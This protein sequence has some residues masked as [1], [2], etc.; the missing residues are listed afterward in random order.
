MRVLYFIV[1]ININNL[2]CNFGVEI[3]PGGTG[4]SAIVV[5]VFGRGEPRPWMFDIVSA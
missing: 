5:H 3:K 4:R 1:T 2:P